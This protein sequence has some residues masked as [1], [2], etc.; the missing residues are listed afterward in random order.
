MFCTF[1]IPTINRSTLKRS[2]DSVYA[3]TDQDW[4]IVVAWNGLVDV[5]QAFK[6]DDPRVKHVTSGGKFLGHDNVGAETRNLGLAVAEGEWIAN[7]DDDDTV[8]P[9]YVACLKKEAEGFDLIH[10]RT[11]YPDPASDTRP[12]RGQY[13][14][15]A[16]TVC[17]SHAFRLAFVR[18]HNIT[19]IDDKNEDW[20]TFKAMLDAGAR[21]KMS[22]Y[23]TYK[24]RF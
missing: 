2:V 23:A 7:L 14:F 17:N 10:F 4:G 19:Y 22:D 15:R 13:A 12:S 8:T 11:L 24:F 5:P 1:L 9:D 18:E 20:V 21:A 3:Q 6:T 16:D